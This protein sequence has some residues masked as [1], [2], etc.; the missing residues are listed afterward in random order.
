MITSNRPKVNTYRI[1]QH[2]GLCGEDVARCT[3][4]MWKGKHIFTS[5]VYGQRY[6]NKHHAFEVPDL[7]YRKA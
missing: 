3:H 1:T 2:P 7:F 4:E 6:K 5:D